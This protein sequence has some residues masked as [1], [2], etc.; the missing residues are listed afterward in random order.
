VRGL[1]PVDRDALITTLLALSRLAQ[2]RPDIAAVD[3]NP[4]V[5]DGSRPVAVDALVLFT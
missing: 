4:L 5:I 3:I 1:P 2:E